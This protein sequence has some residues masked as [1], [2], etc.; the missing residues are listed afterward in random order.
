VAAHI[1]GLRLQFVLRRTIADRSTDIN[2][3]MSLRTSLNLL[4]SVAAAGI[5]AQYCDLPATPQWSST[6]D[7]PLA[8]PAHNWTS[9]KDFSHVPYEGQHLVYGSNVN[10]GSYGSM[11]FG[12]FTN[13]SDMATAEQIG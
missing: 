4:L 11:A 12:L 2:S 3:T 1:C 8:Q 5:N 13:W 6:P 10:N 7:G 9:L